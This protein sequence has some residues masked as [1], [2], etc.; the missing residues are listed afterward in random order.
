MAVDRIKQTKPASRRTFLDELEPSPYEITEEEI[1]AMD[2]RMRKI[3][4]GIDYSDDDDD[5][6]EEEPQVTDEDLDAAAPPAIHEEEKAKKVATKTP[7]PKKEEPAIEP[8]PEPF[9]PVNLFALPD[10][11]GPHVTLVF[12][13][14]ESEMEILE[15]ASSVRNFDTQEAEGKTWHCARFLPEH[16]EELKKITDLLSKRESVALFNGKR[17]PYGRSLWLP[18]MYIFTAGKVE[19]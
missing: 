10:A 19:E 17:V 8:E 18:L 13:A 3:L 9:D 12:P 16:A 6:L 2:P 14:D 15:I 1:A 4:F 11:P 7:E 5:I